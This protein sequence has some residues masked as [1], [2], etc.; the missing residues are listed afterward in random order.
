MSQ[1]NILV[2]NTFFKATSQIAI[3]L[4]HF[5][6][7]PLIVH[8][9]GLTG[10]G[11]MAI[12]K[13]LTP[14]GPIGLLEFGFP[15]AIIPI[16]AQLQ[17]EKKFVSSAKLNGLLLIFFFVIGLFTMTLLFVPNLNLILGTNQIPSDQFNLL[18]LYTLLG[19]IFLFPKLIL[20]G[21]AEGLQNYKLIS[22]IDALQI[23]LTNLGQITLLTLGF[24]LSEL[25]LLELIMGI[26]ATLVYLFKL[27]PYFHFGRFGTEEYIQL[28]KLYQIS[29]MVFISKLSGLLSIN[30][31]KVVI[32]KFFGANYLG[33]FDIMT[34]LPKFL[35]IFTSIGTLA[36]TPLA[37]SLYAMKDHSK[38]NSLFEKGLF[39][40][41]VIFTGILS[42]AAIFA[43]SFFKLW[44]GNDFIKY[45]SGTQFLLLW[46]Y[47]F[48]FNIGWS[49][50]FGMNRLIG[51]STIINWLGT[52]I[53]IATFYI[54]LQTL[55]E[56]AIIAAYLV[57]QVLAFV[58]LYYFL[59]EFKMSWKKFFK[60]FCLATFSFLPSLI[61]S[62]LFLAYF[63]ITNYFGLVL[64]STTILLIY[65]GVIYIVYPDRDFIS[66]LILSRLK[67]K[68]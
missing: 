36:I 46:T 56:D 41:L 1:T 58:G 29:K 35:R 51:T 67:N 6:L 68:L 53:K 49:M 8:H 9:L 21:V 63:V 52:L 19:N 45:I 20:Q 28:K 62:K 13:L 47:F 24:Q 42:T 7:I 11:I 18:L 39:F 59:V 3:T 26:I 66:K 2:N 37:A 44:L 40:N 14:E 16:T 27:F 30:F 50:L 23:I 32:T 55:K 31:D 17:T 34:K 60:L 64:F 57:P 5:A 65:F 12:F 10:L 43:P 15:S 4:S 61:L 48:V 22:T 25:I 38:L 54:T 33:I